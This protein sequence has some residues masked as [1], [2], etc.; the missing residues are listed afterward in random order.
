[1]D[2]IHPGYGFL[3]E[4][5][6]LARACAEAGVTFIGPPAEVL[7]AFGD[8]VSARHA[9]ERTQVPVVPASEELPD[10]DAAVEQFARFGVNDPAVGCLIG[11]DAGSGHS[12][13]CGFGSRA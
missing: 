12:S 6:A 13:E 5:P 1:M 4:N 10:D 11:R 9:A 7:E 8:K 2:A 3:S